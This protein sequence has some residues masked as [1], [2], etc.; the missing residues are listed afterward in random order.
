MV[1]V[2]VRVRIRVRVMV[3]LR[4]RVRLRVGVRLRLR[5]VLP[6]LCSR[7]MHAQFSG[8][9]ARAARKTAASQRSG[10]P[11]WPSCLVRARARV[12]VGVGVGVRVRWPGCLGP[13]S[14]ICEMWGLWSNASAESSRTW[15]RVGLRVRFRVRVRG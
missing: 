6:D 13:R 10:G 12:R 4:V 9:M 2:R 11:G 14:R 8:F 7:A 15:S 3:R 1:R 5:V